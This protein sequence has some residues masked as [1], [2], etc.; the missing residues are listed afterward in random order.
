[1]SFPPPSAR[2]ARIIWMASTGLALVV[3]IGV[4][5]AMVWGLSRVMHVLAPVLWP[6]A[7]AGVLAYLLDPVVDWIEKKGIPRTRAILL[8]FFVATGLL[9]AVLSSV[10]PRVVVETGQLI[11]KIPV[12]TAKAQI[13]L[14][15]WLQNP[16]APLQRLIPESLLRTPQTPATNAVPP[17]EGSTETS[18]P[19]PTP[20]GTTNTVP[21][22]VK[23]DPKLNWDVIQQVSG[24]V[25][26]ALPRVG[27]WI[28]QRVDKLAGWFGLVA[29]L[30][31]VPI[32]LFYFLLE[33]RAIAGQW[34]QY[35]PIRDSSI[36]EEIVFV[37]RSINDYLI[38]FF[39]GQVLV[40][41]C[42]SVLYTIG[43]LVIG[44]NY[45][46]LLGFCAVF[47]TIIPYIGAFIICTSAVLL[48]FVQFGD[49]THG[50]L[51]LAVFAVVQVIEGFVLQ[52]KILGDKVGLHPLAI[53]I[54]VIAG[55]TL[56]GG[57]L[58]GI[59]AIPVTAALRVILY[60][61]VWV[62]KEE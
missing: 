57:L 46:F 45:A 52:P 8:V 3:I 60:R 13:S 22:T 33:K 12:Y 39:R 19:A 49:V 53:I 15:K 29:G 40:A 44:L 54:A 56:L 21:T 25:A 58:G 34:T 24:W 11:S 6:L 32:Y 14:E 16:P 43:F 41:L 10:I 9:L 17:A 2:Q 4:I 7:I 1:M 51:P 50:L 37:I 55:T 28:W 48:A 61:Y 31:L 20:K 5:V 47:L 38:A 35:L 42:D 27:Q 26:S 18:A 36:K 59:L 30:A 62:K 23:L